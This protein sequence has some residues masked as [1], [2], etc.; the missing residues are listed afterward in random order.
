MTL[1]DEQY[2]LQAIT[3]DVLQP[4]APGGGSWSAEGLSAEDSSAIWKLL[5]EQLGIGGLGTAERDGG[6]GGTLVDQLVVMEELGR[7][8][9]HVPFLASSVVSAHVLQEGSNAF[10][11]ELQVAISAGRV[12]ATTLNP[13]D[14]TVQTAGPEEAAVSGHLDMVLDA[15]L[16]DWILVPSGPDDPETLWAIDTR[17][18][19]VTIRARDG[20]DRGWSVQNVDLRGAAARRVRLSVSAHTALKD[21]V[22]LRDLAAAAEA[23]GIAQGALSHTL[24]YVKQRRQFG[25]PI[26]SFQAVQHSCADMLVSVES[27]RVLIKE[28][29]VAFP[30]STGHRELLASTSATYAMDAAQAVCGA[31]IHLH[32]GI[33]FTW[34]H[35]AHRYFKRVAALRSM[36]T[37]RT[38]HHCRI[39]DAL[40][41]GAGS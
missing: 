3:R 31:A 26:G 28:A 12:V 10:A 20:I 36:T 23:V 29:A 14:T 2:E 11:R 4:Y 9:V 1:T 41:G 13:A 39:V 16:A 19:G 32:G 22:A 30:S 37:P 7:A 15:D 24:M 8:L 35:W 5:T 27:S 6:V 33:G 18:R 34:E 17:K 25:Q 40:L 21:A 38:R